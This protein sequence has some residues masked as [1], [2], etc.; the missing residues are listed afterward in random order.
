MT[1]LLFERERADFPQ[2]SSAISRLRPGCAWW[3]EEESLENLHW[4][5]SNT[6]DPP[7]QEEID[8]E[9]EIITQEFIEFNLR[10]QRDILLYETDWIVTKYAELGQPVPDEWKT[11]RQALRDI[12]QNIDGLVID[13]E[14]ICMVGNVNWPQKPNS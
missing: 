2:V 9:I 6:V 8:A 13:P 3:M 5:E 7:T 10:R 11:Y 14:E 4:E 12:T 1:R